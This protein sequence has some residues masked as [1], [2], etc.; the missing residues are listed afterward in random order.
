MLSA[1]ISQ[2]RTILNDF[3]ISYEA[4][5]TKTAV[6]RA[7]LALGDYERASRLLATVMELFESLGATADVTKVQMLQ[8]NFKKEV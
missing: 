6:S 2:D 3:N 1:M 8:A 5:R 7:A 4:A